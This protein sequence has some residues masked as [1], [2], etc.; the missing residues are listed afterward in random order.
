MRGDQRTTCPVVVGINVSTSCPGARV[1]RQTMLTG[2]EA[3]R[4]MIASA[5]FPDS[6]TCHRVRVG[7]IKSI[8]STLRRSLSA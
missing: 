4:S 2:A 3:A 7:C 5:T 1:A 6:T 8:S